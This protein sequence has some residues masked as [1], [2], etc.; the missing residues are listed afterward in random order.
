MKRLASLFILL[1]ALV[2]R[3]P[4]PE[5]VPPP[6]KVTPA[7]G[8]AIVFLGDSITA[9]CLC[10]QYLEN[11]FYTRH[12]HL[13]LHFHNAGVS[14]DT[15]ADA[16]ARFDRD[17]GAYKP[18]CVTVLLGMNDGAAKVFAPALFEKYLADMRML[19]AKIRALNGTPIL[20]TPTVDQG[21]GDA[22]H[23]GGH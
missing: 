3:L 7:A 1:F 21:R 12:P 2:A 6:A 23:R 18:K 17:V 4:A 9:Q 11:Y 8:D 19:V 22:L 20:I 16:L 15:V 13:C 5:S 10:T 14:G